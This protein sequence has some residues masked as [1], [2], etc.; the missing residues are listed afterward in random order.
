[1]FL[2]YYLG[3]NFPRI[4]FMINL[5]LISVHDDPLLG[6]D[7]QTKQKTFRLI[8][9]MHSIDFQ[10]EQILYPRIYLLISTHTSL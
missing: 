9:C 8:V 3:A 7:Q 4:D 10:F 5:S 6:K 2:G 1:M